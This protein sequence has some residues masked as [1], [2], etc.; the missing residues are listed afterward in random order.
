MKNPS[1]HAT[2]FAPSSRQLLPSRSIAQQ[3]TS[4]FL[5]TAVIAIFL[6]DA[7]PRNIR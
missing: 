1:P 4:N 5:A 7:L 2:R 6:R 3:R